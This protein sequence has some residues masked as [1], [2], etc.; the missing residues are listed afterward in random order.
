MSDKQTILIVEDHDD[1]RDMLR[2]A[3]ETEGYHVVE[4]ANGVK[5]LPLVREQLTD[6]AGHHDALGP[7]NWPVPSRTTKT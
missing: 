7:L 2:I 3:L 6:P 4:A 1:T 5:L